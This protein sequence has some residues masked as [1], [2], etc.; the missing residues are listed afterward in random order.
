MTSSTA[1]ALTSSCSPPSYL[2]KGAGLGCC[3]CLGVGRPAGRHTWRARS[4]RHPLFGPGAQRRAVPGS[5]DPFYR[6]HTAN[7]GAHDHRASHDD[8]DNDGSP[9]NRPACHPAA[10]HPA[11][12]N[13]ACYPGTG[14]VVF[15]VDAKAQSSHQD[16][17]LGWLVDRPHHRPGCRRGGPAAHRPPRT[18][19][20]RPLPGSTGPVRDAGKSSV[21]VE[22]RVESGGWLVVRGPIG[23]LFCRRLL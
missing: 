2:R 13:G 17:R 6:D 19:E 3:S 23:A 9:H 20:S 21:P 4:G 18:I 15:R 5:V 11:C 22:T 10:Y 1:T 16:V 14:P 12:D 8:A 7:G